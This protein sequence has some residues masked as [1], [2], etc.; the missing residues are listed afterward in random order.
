MD[1]QRIERIARACHEV[2]RGYCVSLADLSQPAWEDAP[3]WQ[4]SSA[5]IGVRKIL[6]GD[7]RRPQ[8]SHDSWHEQKVLDGWSYGPVKDPVLKQHPCMVPFDELP[9]TQQFKDTLFLLTARS[10][11][12]MPTDPARERQAQDPVVMGYNA[13]RLLVKNVASDVQLLGFEAKSRL[14]TAR[15]AL[16]PAEVAGEVVANLM[17]TY[18]HLEDASMRLGKAIQARDGGESVYDR[19]TTV[20]A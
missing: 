11:L 19:A 10:M 3:E 15:P 13:M 9:A 5:R 16:C 14:A 2:N 7:V 6:S 1:E 18:R 12:N 8:D 4:K 20:G 17:L